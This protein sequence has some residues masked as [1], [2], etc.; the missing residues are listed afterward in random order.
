[1]MVSNSFLGSFIEVSR[2]FH[3]CFKEVSKIFQVVS[4]K[5]K[6]FVMVFQ[7]SSVLKEELF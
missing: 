7:G 1:M 6:A 5:F 3:E 2:V 4:K